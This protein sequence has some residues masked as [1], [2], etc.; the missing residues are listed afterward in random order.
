MMDK[1][2][3]AASLIKPHSPPPIRSIAWERA[4]VDRKALE[5]WK[6]M[7]LTRWGQNSHFLREHSNWKNQ[8]GVHMKIHGTDTK[9]Y[10]Q[11]TR[12]ITGHAP[13]GQYRARFFPEEPRHCPECGAFQDR[14]HVMFECERRVSTPALTPTPRKMRV[15]NRITD[16][17][18]KFTKH[19]EL[20]PLKPGKRKTPS[21]MASYFEWLKLNPAAFTFQGAP[22]T[23]PG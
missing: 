7:D 22:P 3:K 8:G 18:L 5:I 14:Y 21:I 1:D 2:A 17:N 23:I 15:I 10:A 11:F 9:I 13:I 12:S 4:H 20:S 6:G 19:I 16:R